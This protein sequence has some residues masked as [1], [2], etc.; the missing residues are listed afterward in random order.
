MLLKIADGRCYS[1]NFLTQGAVYDQQGSS[2]SC[3]SAF[4][5]SSVNGV[6]LPPTSCNLE[7]RQTTT[8]GFTGHLIGSNSTVHVPT[9]QCVYNSSYGAVCR[10]PTIWLGR[11]LYWHCLMCCC[12]SRHEV[13][14]AIIRK[15]L[16]TLLAPP[17]TMPPS[18]PVPSTES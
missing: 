8:H 6:V 1:Y 7:A 12:N 3:G 5:T 15:L 4:F 9:R 10:A 16:T 18:M 11:G 2:G 13:H 17:R 14:E